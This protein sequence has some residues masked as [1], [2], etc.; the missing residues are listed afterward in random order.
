MRCVL[1]GGGEII[2]YDYIR[3]YLR[4]DDFIIVC[5]GGQNHLGE[6]GVKPNLLVGDFDSSDKPSGKVE[7]IVLPCEKDDTDSVYAAKEAQKR[8][9]KDFLLLGMTGGRLDHTLCNLSLM[10]YLHRAGATAV[11][12]DERCEITVC[13]DKTQKVGQEFK[14]FSLLNIFGMAQLVDIE[15]AKYNLKGATILEDYQYAVSNEPLAPFAKV[16]VGK[17][18]ALLIKMREVNK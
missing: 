17:G 5:D 15:N 6:L 16:K 12:V 13:A 8:G 11:M 1:I 7:T 14:Y 9:V 18:E 3:D 10:L 2:N 4:S